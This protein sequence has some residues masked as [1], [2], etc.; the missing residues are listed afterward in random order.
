MNL[1]DY[2]ELAKKLIGRS[3][4]DPRILEPIEELEY[5]VLLV[6]QSKLS[7]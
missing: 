4:N 3:F 5:R 1:I 2:D 7:G 6:P